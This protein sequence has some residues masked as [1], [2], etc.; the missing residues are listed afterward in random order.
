M[1]AIRETAAYGSCRT[2][3]TRADACPTGPWTAHRARRPQRSTGALL[4]SVHDEKASKMTSQM[5]G[6]PG[7][8]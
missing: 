5:E 4:V 3:G 6:A 8:R 7:M 2:P 1:T